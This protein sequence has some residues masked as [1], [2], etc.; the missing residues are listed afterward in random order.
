ML[1]GVVGG[2]LGPTPVPWTWLFNCVCKEL[3]NVFKAFKGKDQVQPSAR[4]ELEISAP[5]QWLIEMVL[6]NNPFQYKAYIQ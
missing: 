3:T 4:G 2:A 5:F 1:K 6:K